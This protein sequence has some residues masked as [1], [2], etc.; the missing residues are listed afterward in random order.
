MDR[1]VPTMTVH[2]FVLLVESEKGLS[3]LRSCLP[4]LCGITVLQTYGIIAL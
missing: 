2:G 4:V 1:W 3:S